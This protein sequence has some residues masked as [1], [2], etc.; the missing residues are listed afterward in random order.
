MCL[1]GLLRAYEDGMGDA[2]RDYEA[3][4]LSVNEQVHGVLSENRKF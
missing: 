3:L 1:A 2:D 4:Q